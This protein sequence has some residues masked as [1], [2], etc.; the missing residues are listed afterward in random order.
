MATMTHLP[1]AGTIEERSTHVL[2]VIK[3]FALL[4]SLAAADGGLTLAETSKQNKM[5]AS[6]AHR[7]LQTMIEIGYVRQDSRTRRYHLGARTFSLAT[8]ARWRTDIEEIALP[9]ARRLADQVEETVRVDLADDTEVVSIVQVEPT[10]ASRLFSSA[11]GRMPSY[12]TAGGKVLLANLPDAERGKALARLNLQS[13]TPNTI[14]Q[15]DDLEVE[16]DRVR[17]RGYAIDDEEQDIG[18]RSVAAAIRNHSGGVVAAISVS[19]PTGRV[20]IHRLPE[21]ASLVQEA[22]LQISSEL[23]FT[24]QS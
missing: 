7:L 15:P 24:E 1:P 11:G 3:A 18:V 2:S 9:I 10:K 16:L 4:E 5:H 13:Y 19:G 21:L 17:R 8:P 20:T 22:A 14:T 12:C 6:T 23:G